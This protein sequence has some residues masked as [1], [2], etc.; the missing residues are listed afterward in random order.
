MKIFNDIFTRIASRE[1]LFDA[2]DAFRIGKQ[3]KPDVLAFEWNLEPNLFKLHRELRAGA[4]QHGPYQSFHIR[5]PKPRHIH[6]ATV[7]DR[8][9]HHALYN[10]LNP[11]FE[12]AFIADSFSC[13]IGKGTHKGVSRLHGLLRKVSRNNTKPCYALKCD[14]Q[15][16]FASVDQKILLSQIRK[17]IRDVRTLDLIERVITSYDAVGTRERERERE[18]V[19]MRGA[20]SACQSG[21]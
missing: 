13:R 10:I 4:Y 18:R 2:W 3:K 20:A 8:I 17:R 11:I 5:D 6:K 19:K 14:I 7:R 9:V 1:N 16:F 15:K 21:I 12:P